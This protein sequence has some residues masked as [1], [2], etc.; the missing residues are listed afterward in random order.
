MSVQD[1]LDFRGEYLEP[2]GDDHF[3][4]SVDQAQIAIRVEEAD[5]SCAEETIVGEGRNVFFGPP[6][7]TG[8]DGGAAHTYLAGADGDLV[9]ILAP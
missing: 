9:V 7:I 2:R 8:H 6:P 4:F 5:V 1:P 3:L